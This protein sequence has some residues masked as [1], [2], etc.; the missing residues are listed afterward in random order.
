MRHRPDI[1]LIMALVFVHGTFGMNFQIT[2]AL[3]ATQVFDKGVTDYGIVGS[4]MA[5]GSLSGALISARRERPRWRHLLLAMAAFSLST[6]AVALA[7]TF[8]VFTVML[9]P[10]GLSALMVMTTANSM[11]QL[12]VDPAVRGRVMSLYLAVFMGGTPLGSPMI[13]WIGEH[14]GARWTVLVATVMCGL[15]VTAATIFLMR[16]DDIRLR[17]TREHGRRLQLERG[18]VEPAPQKAS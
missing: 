5:I 10:T 12:S 1:M 4:V 6:L 11:V 2:N 3:M 18:P 8:T 17:L 9:V 16:Q 14:L 13:G 15:A 7:P